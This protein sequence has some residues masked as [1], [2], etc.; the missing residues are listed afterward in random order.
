MDQLA[1]AHEA[2]IDTVW[3]NY[4]DGGRKIIKLDPGMAFGTGTHPTTKMSLFCL[5]AGSS[6]WRNG[7]GCGDSGSGVLLLLAHSRCHEN[8]RL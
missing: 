4:G 5:G 6:W 1:S 8:L 3:M 7:A 2:A